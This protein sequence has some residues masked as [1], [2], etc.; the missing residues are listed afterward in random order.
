MNAADLRSGLKVEWNPAGGGIAVVEIVAFS[1]DGISVRS[2]DGH[3]EYHPTSAWITLDDIC[4]RWR[5]S[6]DQYQTTTA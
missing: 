4:A 5:V 3:V 6:A 2:S 1:A